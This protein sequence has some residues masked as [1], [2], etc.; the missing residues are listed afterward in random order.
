[1]KWPW[2]KGK[3]HTEQLIDLIREDRAAT[4]ALQTRMMDVL[5]AHAKQMERHLKMFEDAPAP[6]VRVM[7]DVEEAVYERERSALIGSIAGL[8]QTV[9][10]FDPSTW[11]ADIDA[12]KRE[13]N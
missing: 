2:S 13:M 9:D 7:T 1:M 8:T 4:A 6:T 3:S 11:I 5:D 12:L 10:D